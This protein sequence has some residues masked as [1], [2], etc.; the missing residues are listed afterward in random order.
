MTYATDHHR[1]DGGGNGIVLLQ[2]RI[3][4]LE[5]DGEG[6]YSLALLLLVRKEIAPSLINERV[7]IAEII[8]ESFLELGPCYNV[9]RRKTCLVGVPYVASSV[10]TKKGSGKSD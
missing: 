9:V 2:Y 7:F 4:L 5:R 3:N 8:T 10:A 6:T 1:L